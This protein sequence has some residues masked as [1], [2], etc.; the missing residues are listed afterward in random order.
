M[1]IWSLV[2]SPK[3]HRHHSSL[4]GLMLVVMFSE[5][6]PVLGTGCTFGVPLNGDVM[7]QIFPL[8][9]FLSQP[10]SEYIMTTLLVTQSITSSG[11]DSVHL[12]GIKHKRGYVPLLLLLCQNSVFSLFMVYICICFTLQ[13]YFKWFFDTWK[14]V[15]E[16][17]RIQGILGQ[18]KC[19]WL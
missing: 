5:S 6:H 9:E 14:V 16:I 13:L 2:F 12:H 18:L 11:S 15:G 10:E 17:Y 4:P 3:H 1:L 19:L 7:E 8:I